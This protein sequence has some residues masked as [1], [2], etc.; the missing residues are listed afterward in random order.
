MTNN[1]MT[2]D[3]KVIRDSG[4]PMSEGHIHILHQILELEPHNDGMSSSCDALRSI[5]LISLLLARTL[6]LCDCY[7]PLMCNC[8][9]FC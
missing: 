6:G 7:Y 4:G 8:P 9:L 3:E 1:Q 2:A 5:D